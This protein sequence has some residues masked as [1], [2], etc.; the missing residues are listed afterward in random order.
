[1]SREQPTVYIGPHLVR[2]E[3]PDTLFFVWNGD[4][5]PAELSL[6]FDMIE[7][8]G[9][10]RR[11]VLTVHDISRLHLLPPDTRRLAAHDPR[12]RLLGAMAFFGGRSHVRAIVALV[13][14]VV[15][16]LRIDGVMPAAF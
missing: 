5:T 15:Q 6:V 3:P 1:M 10:G 9:E 7:A 12:T 11:R 4:V 16:V 2:T 14:K 8:L 13:V